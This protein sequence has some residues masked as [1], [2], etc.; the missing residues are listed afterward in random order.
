MILIPRV[1]I[2]GVQSGVGKTTIA[3]GLMAA[4]AKKGYKVQGFKA[5]PDYIDPG[6]HTAATGNISRNLDGWMLPEKTI[7][8]L[9]LKAAKD[10]DVSVIEGVMGLYDGAG[11]DRQ[12]GSTAQLA[13]Y[14]SAPVILVVNAKGMAA[15]AAALVLGYKE[16]DPEINFGG[17][18][19]NNTG[20]EKHYQILKEAVEG[21]TGLK[22]LGHLKKNAGL[23]MP[24]R[25][26]GLVPTAE[27]GELASFLD[28]LAR[29]MANSVDL[30]EI[31]EV[32][33]SAPPLD[34]A[35]QSI[36]PE[37]RKKD[38]RIAVARDQ[39]F[40]FYYQDALD[41]LS[42]QG[43]ELAYFSPLADYALPEDIHGI[44]IGGGFPE[45]FLEALA[46]NQAMIKSIVSAHRL[47]MPV[48]AECGGLMYLSE[49]IIDFAGNYYPMAD[50]IPGK[51][52]MQKKLAALGYMTAEVL[53]DNILAQKGD[54]IKGHQFRWS[55]LADIPPDASYA[56]KLA[57]GRNTG[58]LKEG[59]A[60]G[61]LLASYIHLHFASHP[62][63]ARNF[64]ESCRRYR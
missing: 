13:R 56:Y 12:T 8:E 57:G 15:S 64:V 59:I 5:G 21:A 61:N 10:A 40:N 33:G 6:Y 51:A 54:I 25:H 47:G 48:Y 44:Y 26:L 63:L 38:V 1:V 42:A 31:L 28:S 45:V 39:A 58:D 19:F 50:L 46:R 23:K 55:V 62:W 36:F 29:V 3:T 4:L 17:V 2:A 9:F 22:V 60:T 32:A 20:S 11:E 41:L 24:E 49:G 7:K 35:G 16:F 37:K 34:Y 14:L 43:A 30:E 27:K 53:T 18:I 52:C